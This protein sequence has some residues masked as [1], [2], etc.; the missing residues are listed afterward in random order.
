MT[1]FS[2]DCRYGYVCLLSLDRRVTPIIQPPRYR[3]NARAI[4]QADG[5][6][7]THP[8]CG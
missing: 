8:D 6:F 7:Q 2:T 3:L 5:I 1:I 4:E